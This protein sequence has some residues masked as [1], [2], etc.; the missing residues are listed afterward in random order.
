MA[1]FLDRLAD[2]GNELLDS[3]T[4]SIS[5]R[6]DNEL[7]DDFLP[8]P[9]NATSEAPVVKTGTN[10]SGF[11]KTAGTGA[12]WVSGIPN[13]VALAVGV[14]FVGLVTYLALK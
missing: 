4:V 14:G 7:N 9:A 3:A 13:T 11:A 8:S 2:K 5:R 12:Q 1:S 6:I 10:G